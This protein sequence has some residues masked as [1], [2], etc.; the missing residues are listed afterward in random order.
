MEENK[1]LNTAISETNI[2]HFENFGR[3][4]QFFTTQIKFKGKSIREWTLYFS[5]PI[6]EK[7]DFATLKYLISDISRKIEMCADIHSELKFSSETL[8]AFVTKQIEDKSARLLSSDRT[9]KTRTKAESLARGEYVNDYVE[10]EL[11]KITVEFF[12]LQLK[13]LRSIAS[14]LEVLA[15]ATMSEMKNITRILPTQ[16]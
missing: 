13:K 10:V 2:A 6:P 7:P 4:S 11:G 12:E 14:N 9:I 15:N 8:S 1:N 3:N 5:V 16:D